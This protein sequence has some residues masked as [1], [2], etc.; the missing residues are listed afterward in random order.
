MAAETREMPENATTKRKFDA[1]RG[2]YALLNWCLYSALGSSIPYLAFLLLSHAFV[3]AE[4]EGLVEL[5]GFYFSIIVP[6]VIE[7][8]NPKAHF[9]QARVLLF[10]GF[11]FFSMC[12][13]YVYYQSFVGH[14]MVFEEKSTFH[15]IIVGLGNVCIG[16]VAILRFLQGAISYD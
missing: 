6:E 11:V 2:M 10:L 7:S 1:I 9:R 13:F 5:S 12:Y 4:V 3:S 14:K 16:L 8:I 15:A